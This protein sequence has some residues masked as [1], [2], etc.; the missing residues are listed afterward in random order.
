MEN[1]WNCKKQDP[2]IAKIT[3][4]PMLIEVP[5]RKLIM[6]EGQGDPNQEGGM[7]K[8]AM[9][10]M[11]ALC[12][13]IKMSPKTK[14][15]LEGYEPF[16][17]APLEGLW[18]I[19]GLKGMDY[20][21]KADFHWISMIE[22]PP[23][24][25]EDVFAWAIQEVLRKKPYLKELKASLNWLDEGLCMTALHYGPY[26][27]EPATMAKIDE[28]MCQAKVVPDLSET[29]R[30]HEIY[31]SDARRCAPEKNRTLIRVPVKKADV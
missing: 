15:Q 8:R 19:P 14:V 30:H 26:D 10:L 9:E 21:R 18:W 13:T 22:Q 1:Q 5:A 17:V 25:S 28:A 4:K 3:A 11:Y 7:Y 20:S 31:L 16:T 2:L 29:R 27:D 24:V 23:F 6:I 12:Y